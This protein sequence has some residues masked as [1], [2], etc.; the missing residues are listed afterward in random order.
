MPLLPGTDPSKPRYHVPTRRTVPFVLGTG[1][2][3]YGRGCA[4]IWQEV[5]ALGGKGFNG[6]VQLLRLRRMRL[7]AEYATAI[8]R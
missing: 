3:S 4:L 5:R 7:S 1:V 8:R 6:G 2:A